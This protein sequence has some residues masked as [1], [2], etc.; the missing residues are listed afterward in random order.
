M[1]ALTKPDSF[2]GGQFI[3][4]QFATAAGQVN[5]N[6][7]WGPTMTQ[8]YEDLRNGLSQAV[9]GGGTISDALTSAQAKTITAMKSQG[10]QV[11]S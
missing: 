11:G 3:W 5:N 9:Q 6:W 7:Q 2:F 1:P 8:T 10:I 4:K